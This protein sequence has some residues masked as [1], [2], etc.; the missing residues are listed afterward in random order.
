LV[1]GP[2]H[3][4]EVIMDEVPVFHRKLVKA[5]LERMNLPQEH[6]FARFDQIAEPMQPVVERY[7][8]NIHTRVSNSDGLYIYGPSGVGKTTLAAVIAKEARAHGFTVYFA[9]VWE[10]R[11]MIRARIDFD[12]ETTMVGRAR[13][14][15][16]LVLDDLRVEDAT[17]KFFSVADIAALVKDRREHKHVTLVTSTMTAKTLGELAAWAP[18]RSALVGALV[19]LPLEGENHLTRRALEKAR[20]VLGK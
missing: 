1:W 19:L 3:V 15:D 18:F 8:R 5:D 17:E 13:G 6:W 4:S 12:E 10:L 14:V 9:R 2:E 20:E 7:I 11:E 16:V